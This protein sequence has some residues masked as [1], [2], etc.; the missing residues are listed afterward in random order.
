MPPH[1]QTT[2]P[3]NLREKA[4]FVFEPCFQKALPSF[5]LPQVV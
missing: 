3:C 2:S 1:S 4:P 5:H